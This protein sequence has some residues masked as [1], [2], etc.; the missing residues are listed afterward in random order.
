[1]AEMKYIPDELRN[2]H[3]CGVRPGEAHISGCDT[4]RCSVCGGQWIACGHKRHDPQ[5]ARWTGIFPGHGEAL[6]LGLYSKWDEV[7]HAWV[8]CDR[9]DPEA[10]ADINRFEGLGLAKI[11]FVKP[12]KHG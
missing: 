6:A 10:D 11:F 2:C 1:M 9:L 7:N 12:N 8:K 5:F 4:E 3:D